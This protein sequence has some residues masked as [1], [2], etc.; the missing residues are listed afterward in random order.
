MQTEFNVGDRVSQKDSGF[1][2]PFKSGTINGVNVSAD[3]YVSYNVMWDDFDWQT[4]DWSA[5]DFIL[6]ESN[7]VG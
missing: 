7:L 4:V 1:G 6:L 3:G 2:I 5:E